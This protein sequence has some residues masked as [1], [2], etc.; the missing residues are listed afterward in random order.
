VF[1]GVYNWLHDIGNNT[2]Q[3]DTEMTETQ[4]YEAAERKMEA[5]ELETGKPCKIIAGPAGTYG[6][7]VVGSCGHFDALGSVRITH[8]EPLELVE[9]DCGVALL[10]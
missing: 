4:N 10:S 8:G 2:Q 1:I 5:L 6:A 3:G 7:V 9:E